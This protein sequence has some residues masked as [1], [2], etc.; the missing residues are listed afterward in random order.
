LEQFGYAVWNLETDSNQLFKIL[1]YYLLFQVYM[2]DV[3]EREEF[4]MLSWFMPI[5]LQ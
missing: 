3:Y 4:S 5:N 1:L 2:R